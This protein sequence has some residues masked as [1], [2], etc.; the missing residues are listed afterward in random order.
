MGTTRLGPST[1][2]ASTKVPRITAIFWVI[3]VLSTGMGETAADYVDKR[4]NPIIPVLIA[5]S[6]L[7]AALLWQLKASKY[8][9]KNYWLA[10]VMVSVFGTMIADAA[11]VALG[12]PYCI[13]TPIF[14]VV[15]AAL[16]ATWYATEKS[17]SVHSII[18]TRREL[19]YWSV[20]M[21]TFA[22]GTAVG[23][24]TAVTF[25]WGFFTSGITFAVAIAI[26]GIA[27]KFFG[28]NSVIAF[29]SAYVITR[30]LGASFADWMGVS[31]QRGGLGWGPG[32]VTIGLTIIIVILV[33]WLPR[34]DSNQ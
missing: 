25:K 7:I 16:F 5:A 19:F 26:P 34:L 9:P 17:L 21:A 29:W 8:R 32:S 31:P 18:N 33:L 10:V 13:S 20:V 24:L 12:I 22:L 3:K 28:L 27:C 2:I 30:P 6:I 15:L 23:D 4:F 14:T 1:Q 11:H